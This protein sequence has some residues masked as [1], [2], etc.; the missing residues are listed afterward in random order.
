MALDQCTQADD[1]AG[2]QQG[3]PTAFGE[4]FHD[5]DHQDAT[6]DGKTNQRQRQAGFPARFIIAVAP[7]VLAQAQQRQREGDEHVDAVQHHQYRNIA[8]G[9][10]QDHQRA[11]PHQEYAILGHQPPGQVAEM[12]RHPGINRHVGQHRWPA[13]K[14]GVGGHEQQAGFQEQHDRQQAMVD[15]RVQAPAGD[16]RAEGDRIQGLVRYFLRVPE[17]I[18]QDD[19]AGGEAQRAGHVEHGVFAGLDPRLTQHVDVIGDRF[20]PGVGAAA[21]RIGAQKQ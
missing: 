3:Q 18:E 17:Q 16:D 10:G 2:D 4:L 12:A 1:H 15:Q 9:P 8:L 13:E 11:Q 6:G 14:A 5:C 21:Q 19:A 7:P 20:Q